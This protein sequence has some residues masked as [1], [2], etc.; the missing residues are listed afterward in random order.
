MDRFSNL[1]LKI[2]DGKDWRY[3][4][5]ED[6]QDY[7]GKN[8]AENGTHGARPEACW[9]AAQEQDVVLDCCGVGRA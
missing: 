1:N 7:G 5:P 9:L 2:E 3:D 6:T 4:A 8:Y